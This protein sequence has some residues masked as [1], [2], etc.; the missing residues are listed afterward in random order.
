[1][2]LLGP[3]R[4]SAE[5]GVSDRPSLACLK[6]LRHPCLA[7]VCARLFHLVLRGSA[8]P[9]GENVNSVEAK[10]NDKTTTDRTL[11]PFTY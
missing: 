8:Q 10:A 3:L 2:R 9:D 6:R 7:R 1:M 5:A 11:S 4:F